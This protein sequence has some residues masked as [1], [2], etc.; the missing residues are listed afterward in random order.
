MTD[1]FEERL[2]SAAQR[3][4]AMQQGEAAALDKRRRADEVQVAKI[5]NAIKAW[6]DRIV[7][8]I[9]DATV[10]PNG[11]STWQHVADDL[12]AAT[13]GG[14]TTDVSVALRLVLMLEGVPCT[15]N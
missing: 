8:A 7:P 15:P 5:N 6:K 10:K 13:L 14:D 9:N 1:D 2:K 4:Q 3:K 12:K 11:G